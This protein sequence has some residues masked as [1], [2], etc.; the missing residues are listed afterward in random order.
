MYSL[1][2]FIFPCLYANTSMHAN[3]VDIY[4]KMTRIVLLLGILHDNL[5]INWYRAG[6]I[7]F[8][9]SLFVTIL[10]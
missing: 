3:I 5:H 7:F 8:R 4:D 2:H 9:D 10:A 1:D 6:Y